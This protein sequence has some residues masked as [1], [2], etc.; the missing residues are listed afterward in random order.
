MN[1]LI[2]VIGG[3][4]FL[5][6]LLYKPAYAL[7][8][9]FTM[10]IAAVNFEIPGTGV[11]IRP[12][13]GGLL[14]LRSAFH[15]RL[16]PIDFVR[17][18]AYRL[19]IAYFAYILILSWGK[20]T[21]QGEITRLLLLS[22]VTAYL[23]YY[24]F[25]LENNAGVLKASIIFS[26]LV[27]LADLVYTYKYIGHF[28]VERVYHL[29]FPNYNELEEL[30]DTNHNFYGF[31]CGISLVLLLSEYLN[32]RSRWA[33]AS[34]FLM[35][36]M[37]MGVLMSTSR[38]TLLGLLVAAA[39]LIFRGFRDPV[40]RKRTAAMLTFSGVILGVVLFAFIT[41]QSFFDLDSEFLDNISFR[42]V[43]EPVAVV[44]KNLGYEYNVQNLDAMD[45]R[46]ESAAIAWEAYGRL[47]VG[48]QLT[49]VGIGG[50]LKRNLGQN[51][52]NPHNGI[53][54][55]L[56]ESGLIGFLLYFSMVWIVTRDAFRFKPVSALV[57]V[58][59]F[60]IFYS[61]GQNEELISATAMLFISSLAAENYA[62]KEEDD[63]DSI[64]VTSR[65][66]RAV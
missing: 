2:V 50:Y 44:R 40:S 38:S 11:K 28:P 32:A 22:V 63:P 65:S 46:Q 31:I 8:I 39:Y 49:G 27:C 59:V 42:L 23:G 9:F 3:A 54:Y 19:M 4:A 7:I 18:P 6:L 15:S 36:L 16:L 25:K 47:P 55:I 66:L 51:G 62:L 60:I 24:A 12:L 17:I 35:P 10:T 58:L 13:L 26:G 57:L 29:L 64:T 21:L 61:L 34:L 48:E 20:E 37:L 33:R 53:L 1:L 5:Y 30:N 52:L 41:L 14:V 56:L 43:E 45:W